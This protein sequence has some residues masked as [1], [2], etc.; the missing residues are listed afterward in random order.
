MQSKTVTRLFDILTPKEVASARRIPKWEYD[1]RKSILDKKLFHLVSIIETVY[2]D[3][4][5]KFVGDSSLVTTPIRFIHKLSKI[6]D[7]RARV[8]IS[9][10]IEIHVICAQIK[11]LN[12][13]V[14]D[15]I[16][17]EDPMYI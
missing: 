9:Y 12:E 13:Y 1:I 15:S 5:S 17:Y 8:L 4:V 3:K 2:A 16:E 14:E 10:M 11:M 6:I 7:D